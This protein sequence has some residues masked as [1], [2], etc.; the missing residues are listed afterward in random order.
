MRFFLIK[1]VGNNLYVKNRRFLKKVWYNPVG[2][3]LKLCSRKIH[4]VFGEMLYCNFNCKVGM[5]NGMHAIFEKMHHMF[6]WLEIFFFLSSLA[7]CLLISLPNS[8]LLFF[9]SLSKCSLSYLIF[10]LW[11]SVWSSA[12][13]SLTFSQKEKPNITH[14]SHSPLRRG[15]LYKSPFN[16]LVFNWRDTRTE[17]FGPSGSWGKLATMSVVE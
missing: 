9:S 13:P 16:Q 12:L 3:I 4:W 1:G 5:K 7:P 8:G 6:F 15:S 17:S 2:S 10:K 14:I 11:W